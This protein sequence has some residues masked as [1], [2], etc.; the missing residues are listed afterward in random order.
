MRADA[1]TASR[2]VRASLRS[3]GICDPLLRADIEHCRRLH[4][5]HGRTYYLATW[6]LP[7]QRRPWVWSLYGFFRT[8]DELVDGPRADRGDFLRWVQDAREALDGDTLSAD[9]A[10]RAMVATAGRWELPRAHVEAFL[11]SMTMDLDTTGYDTYADLQRYVHG[12]AEVVG[13][14]MLPLLGSRSPQAPARAAAL[15]RAFQL[16]NFVRDVGEDL[17]RGRLYLPEE[18][19]R[20]FGLVRQDLCAIRAGA[21][22]TDAV[23]E[24]LAFEVARC[25][26]LYREAEPGIDLLDPVS[27]PGVRAAFALYQGILDRVEAEGA[28]V[29]TRRVS[30]PRHTRAAVALPAAAASLLARAR[31]ARWHARI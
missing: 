12:S 31:T 17:D 20:H 15:G 29:L 5:L 26:D 22:M 21:P 9:P 28:P 16:T 14:M 30:V 27:R 3:A 11:I 24:L 6:L 7:P 13:L 10:V 1:G 19:L 25:R 18:D 2:R 8:A 23:R 4:Q